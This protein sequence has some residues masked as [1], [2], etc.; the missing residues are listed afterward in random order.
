[1]TGRAAPGQRRQLFA[2][3]GG[4][5]V[6]A[7]AL[8]ALLVGLYHDA[9]PLL[10]APSWLSEPYLAWVLVAVAMLASFAYVPLEHEGVTEQL[11][12]LEAVAVI[13][14]LLLAPVPALLITS[15][16]FA[17]ATLIRRDLVKAV[18]NVA[19]NTAALSVLIIVVRVLCPP[20]DNFSVR[21]VL[22]LLA[23]TACFVVV[24]LAC[25]G[26]VIST[27]SPLNPVALVRD[28]WRLSAFM[29]VATVAVGAMTVALAEYSPLLLPAVALPA[30]ALTYAY[31]T[32]ALQA[33]ERQQA[34]Q[35]FTLSEVLAGRFDPD[36]LLS[37]FVTTASDA[38]RADHAIVV[39]LPAEGEDATAAERSVRAVALH[40]D[41]APYEARQVASAEQAALLDL[42]GTGPTARLVTTGL[43]DGWRRAAVAPLQAGGGRLGVLVLG[44]RQRQPTDG[45]ERAVAMLTPIASALAF[46]LRGAEALHRLVTESSKLQAVV[47]Q[48][49]DGI[50][51][52]DG[53]GT[54]EV[55]SPAMQALTGRDITE[56][57]GRPLATVVPSIGPDGA[58]IDFFAVGRDRLTVEAPRTT[59]EAAVVRRDGEERWTRCA[60]AG[61]FED[62]TLVRDVVIVHD[63][64]RERRVDR[65]KSD[66][67]ATV[68][69]ELRTPVTPIKGYA[70]L[71][72][73]RGDRMTPEKRLECLDFI[74]ERTG[75]LANL[76]EDLLLASRI[77]NA[78]RGPTH[79]VRMTR[80]DLADV[81]RRAV[82]DVD[83]PERVRLSGDRS[84]VPVT[85]DPLRA[86]QIVTNLVA[87]AVNYSAPDTP[88]EVTLSGDDA[89]AVVGVRDVGRGIP[90]DELEAI[91]EKFHRVEDPM[92]MT[93][94][95]TGLGL[96]IAQQ[97]AY[98][99]HGRIEVD[100]TLGIGSTFRFVLPRQDWQ[101]APDGDASAE[102][103]TVDQRPSGASER[104]NGVPVRDATISA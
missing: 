76:V 27:T 62:S 100:S 99:M 63:V 17:V 11:G 51:V 18:F 28:Q 39:L 54:V 75:H 26:A 5:L 98:A 104:P 103:S 74:I 73:S 25:L 67:I 49:S 85:C 13:A 101:H 10:P 6:A 90:A 97:L 15:I 33:S 53:V 79:R 46:A 83:A 20:Q 72:R 96:F 50:L 47:D 77:S 14:V 82:G 42:V 92:R 55:W 30:A 41:G 57:L 7:V 64:T 69:H 91:F 16:G 87:N 88:V 58:P 71:L 2:L 52:L 84:P 38:F 21:L 9:A 81:V 36:E 60:H 95:G 78:D 12:L 8:V 102:A 43:P 94:S 70:E 1:M 32:R 40:S 45:G 68:S 56:A 31:R 61:V 24:N 19:M 89:E 44:W 86:R 65:L 37:T 29:A 22:S 59:V 3:L 93:T 66:F 80:V 23:G 48:S 4:M 34:A 35:L